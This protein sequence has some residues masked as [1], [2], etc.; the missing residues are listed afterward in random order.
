MVV[1]CQEHRLMGMSI[2][3]ISVGISCL[4]SRAAGDMYIVFTSKQVHGTTATES[5]PC[6]ASAA[7]ATVETTRQIL[8]TMCFCYTRYLTAKPFQE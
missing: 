3:N 8:C 4:L 7:C 5:P 1:E 2:Y 6:H